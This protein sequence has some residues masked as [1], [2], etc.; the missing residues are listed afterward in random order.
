ML[1]AY[2]PRNI[3]QFRDI[4]NTTIDA[5]LPIVSEID[6]N[7]EIHSLVDIEN[8][9]YDLLESEDMYKSEK[10]EPNEII[11]DRA[12]NQGEV[13]K[14]IILRLREKGLGPR[15][16]SNILKEKGFKIEYYQVAYLLK[17]L[18]SQQKT[19]M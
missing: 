10:L 7:S 1:N 12:E 13:L 19:L 4:I 18:I 16:I 6:K 5:A 3:R 14:K 9:P 2:Y 17:K 8:I 11:S 15:K